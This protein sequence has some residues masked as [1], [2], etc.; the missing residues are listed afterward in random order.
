[1]SAENSTRRCDLIIAEAVRRITIA[2]GASD[3]AALAREL[4]VSIRQLERR[5]YADVGLPPKLF[6]RIQRLN[7]VFRAIGQRPSSWVETAVACGYYDQA[8]LIRDF[9]H[10][11]VKR[12]ES[13][14]RRMLTWRVSS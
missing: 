7:C 10:F 13:C 8:H 5:F 12:R 2:Q 6:C 14:C 4:G 9:K 11:P 3:L 1:L